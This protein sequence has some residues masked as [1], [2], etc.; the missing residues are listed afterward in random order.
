MSATATVSRRPGRPR[1]FDL[2]QALDAAI[3]VFSTAGY[4]AASIGE[5]AA[6]MGLTAGSIYKAFPDKR[7]VF[8][9]AFDR[10][11]L[12]RDGMLTEVLEAPGSGRERIRR[13]LQFYADASHGPMGRQGCLV[14]GSAVELARFDPEIG[15]RVTRSLARSEALL[16][17]LLQ[18][19][20]EDGSIAAGLDTAATARTLVFILQ[21]MRVYGKTDPERDA[22]HATIASALKLLD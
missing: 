5:L 15:A 16:T 7:A 19:G 13:M 4:H 6:A 22:M 9:A 11:K 8:L 2:D 14:V 17:R 10:Y 20:L 21:G 3:V 12:V 18:Q 1:S